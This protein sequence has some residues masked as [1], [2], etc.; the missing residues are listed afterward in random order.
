[1]L[2]YLVSR[3]DEK[4]ERFASVM[5]VIILIFNQATT[6]IIMIRCKRARAISMSSLSNDVL[7]YVAD[8]LDMD[9]LI[10]WSLVSQKMRNQVWN[11]VDEARLHQAMREL[12]HIPDNQAVAHKLAKMN[13]MC[14]QGMWGCLFDVET[15]EDNYYSYS[16]EGEEASAVAISN[17]YKTYELY[18]RDFLNTHGDSLGNIEVLYLRGGACTPSF[19]V[20]LGRTFPNVKTLL[21]EE[22]HMYS[23]FTIEVEEGVVPLFEDD[24]RRFTELLSGLPKL[25]TLKLSTKSEGQYMFAELCTANEMRRQK[26]FSD[27]RN[28]EFM[29]GTIIVSD[30]FVL[31]PST[32]TLTLGDWVIGEVEDLVQVLDRLSDQSR[33]P[34]LGH[35]S[36]G[37]SVAEPDMDFDLVLEAIR[38]YPSSTFC[39]VRVVQSDD[40]TLVVL[41]REGIHTSVCPAVEEP[42]YVFQEYFDGL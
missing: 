18:M 26:G 9:S 21:V 25:E 33:Y 11:C 23:S 35:I 7:G 41:N 40:D 32:E 3:Q 2:D 34:K 19:P 36:I 29:E 1:V 6:T 42:D 8:F 31:L 38:K 12:V 10:P 22:F 17:S 30:G 28:L 24:S 15:G 39:E 16:V 27:I 14:F 4:I 13:K 37:V 20:N 5:F